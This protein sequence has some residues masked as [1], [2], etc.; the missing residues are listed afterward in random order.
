LEEEDDD[1]YDQPCGLDRR[2]G[3]ERRNVVTSESDTFRPA[4]QEYAGKVLELKLVSLSD[5]C[6]SLLERHEETL[7]AFR[8]TKE[9]DLACSITWLETSFKVFIICLDRFQEVKAALVRLQE[10]TWGACVEC[11]EIIRDERLIVAP[12]AELCI[13]CALKEGR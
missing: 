2:A 4:L 11:G 5:L 10:G 3:P 13:S 12:E 9:C 7:Q 1:C 8:E 6:D